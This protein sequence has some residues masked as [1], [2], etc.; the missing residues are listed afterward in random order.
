[1]YRGIE[2]LEIVSIVLEP[3]QDN[4]QLIFE[5]LN[6]KGLEL[7]ETDKIRNYLLMGKDLDSQTRLY[8]D[9]WY[10]IEQRFRN[11]DQHFKRFMRHYL[12]LKT[13][14]IPKP[15]V[16]FTRTLESMLK[17]DNLQTS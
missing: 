9:L 6:T 1:M 8:N 16:I 15:R 10:P 14:K 7:S 3:A 13:R 11:E 2:R 5:T 4:P 12:T 17:Q